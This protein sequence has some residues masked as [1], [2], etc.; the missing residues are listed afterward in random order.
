MQYH[1]LGLEENKIESLKLIT[2]AALDGNG[3]AAKWLGEQHIRVLLP[4]K[5]QIRRIKGKQYI[6]IEGE[7]YRL[8]E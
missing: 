7:G 5:P 4:G 8:L 6:Y 1:G 3:E 2:K